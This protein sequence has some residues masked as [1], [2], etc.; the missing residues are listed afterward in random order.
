[1]EFDFQ[2]R[3]QRHNIVQ[4]LGAPGFG[5]RNEAA[6]LQVVA[7]CHLRE[8]AP[9][10]GH[11]GNASFAKAVAVELRDITTVKAQAA[12]AHAVN[13]GNGIDQGGLACTVGA[14]HADQFAGLHMQGHIPQSGGGAVVDGNVADFKHGAVPGKR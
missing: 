14:D 5:R 7:H 6:Q 13:A 8:Q 11:D 1:M 4:R 10:F 2:N 3:E 12:G 9:A